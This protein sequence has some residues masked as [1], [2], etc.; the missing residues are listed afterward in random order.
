MFESEAFRARLF[1]LQI[2]IRPLNYDKDAPDLLK[3]IVLKQK[4]LTESQFQNIFSTWVPG[5]SHP[6]DFLINRRI[7]N[8]HPGTPVFMFEWA[9]D[10]VVRE[11]LWAA[12]EDQLSEVLPGTIAEY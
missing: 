8:A 7:R 10:G 11:R 6:G 4:L 5:S 12:A 2:G 9:E 1:I 3:H